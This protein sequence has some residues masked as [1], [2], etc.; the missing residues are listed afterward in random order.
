MSTVMRRLYLRLKEV[1]LTRKYVRDVLLPDWW[2]DEIAENPAG[3]AEGLLYLSGH[4]GLDLASLQDDSAPLSL[5]DFGTCKF[6]KQGGVSEHD[7]ALARALSTRTA[8]LVAA[9]MPEPPRPLPD[10]PDEIRED[11]LDGGDPWVS[12]DNLLDYCWSLGVPV[13]HLSVFPPKAKKMHAVAA[14][15][16]GRPVIVLCRNDKYPAWLLFDLAHE[17]GHVATGHVSDGGL[18]LDEKILQDST[19]ADEIQANS[20]AIHLLTGIP[21]RRFRARGRWPNAAGLARNAHEAGSQGGIDPG[22][23]VLNYAHSMGRQFFSVGQAALKLL[24][25]HPNAPALVRSK[26]AA[27]L[28]W[29]LLPEESC[30]FLMRVTQAEKQ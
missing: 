13:I 30:E 5:R 25:P 2:D 1:G 7:L 26:M 22:H 9:G 18:L 23:I 27:N 28:D 16:S 6:K 17:L 19:D 4:Q 8:Q 10:S 21:E 12:L 20:F 3:Y 15:V 29:S 14:R 24:E 11:I